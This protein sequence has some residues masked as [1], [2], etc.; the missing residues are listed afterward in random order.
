LEPGLQVW[1][2][3]GA[4]RPPGL[5]VLLPL[6]SLEPLVLPVSQELRAWQLLAASWA[7]KFPKV[8]RA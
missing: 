4:L 8:A 2:V 3:R 1:E 7:L 6:E 5:P